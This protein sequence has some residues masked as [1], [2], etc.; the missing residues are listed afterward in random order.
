VKTASGTKEDL[1][2]ALSKF[3]NVGVGI[4]KTEDVAFADVYRPMLIANHTAKQQYGE[5]FKTAGN[6]GVHPGWA[7]H[8]IM[9]Y[10]FLKG[11][12]VDGDLG[13]V[14]YDEASGKAKAMNGHEVI[15]SESGK[16]SL[17]STRLVFSAS[18]GDVKSAGTIAAGRALV[19]FDDELN[20]FIL[21][22]NAPK[23]A[24][25]DVTWG[26]ITKRYTAEELR[27]GVNLAKDFDKHP[28][29]A[30]F[31]KIWDAVSAKQAYE[32]EQIKKLVHGPEG[33]AD[34]EGTF[35]KSE[36]VRAE[37]AAAIL[38]AK[39]PVDHLIEIKASAN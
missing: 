4:A 29:A 24:N 22:V 38:T 18:P 2:L 7:G 36:M 35:A 27:A 30:P 28:L 12:G 20:R 6:D 21:K 19:P 13:T 15:A 11:L 37:K 31:K 26:E 39:Q 33:K 14:L 10:A 34:M 17:R 8:V 1:N 9:A 32:T 16:I 23:S 25:Y 3:R 5:N